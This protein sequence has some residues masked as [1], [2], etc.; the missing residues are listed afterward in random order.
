MTEIVLQFAASR[1]LS[2]AAI[3][4]FGHGWCSHVDAVLPDGT[5]LGARLDGGVAIRP[6]G[7]YPFTRTQRVV[8]PAPPEMVDAFHAF[9]RAQLGKPYDSLGI[10]AFVAGRDWRDPSRWFCS[11]LACAALETCGYFAYPLATPSNRITPPDLLLACSARVEV[12]A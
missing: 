7:Y 3:E 4:W 11:E 5:L 1:G 6:A 9:L 10:A 8:L 12:A 2:S